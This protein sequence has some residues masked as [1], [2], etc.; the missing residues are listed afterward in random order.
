MTTPAP[1]GIIAAA[2]E[3]PVRLAER[4]MAAGQPV[5]VVALKNTATADFSALPHTYLRVG[6]FKKIL[7]ALKDAGCREVMLAGKFK[8]PNLSE[9]FPDAL[10]SRVAMKIMLAGDDAALKI[11]RDLLAEADLTMVDTTPYLGKTIASPGLIAGAAITDQDMLQVE[12]GC[13]VLKA[14]GE[15]DIGQ[16][17]VIQG[18]RVLAIEAAEGTDEMIY[19]CGDLIDK[20]LGAAVLVKMTKS[21]QD[22]AL[23]PPVIGAETVKACGQVGITI[24][25]IEAGGVIISDHEATL[26]AVKENTASLFGVS[27]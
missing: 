8:R 15:H 3:L 22:K 13:A 10:A 1:M 27:V 7:D 17:V 26:R 6:A 23:D 5:F 11:I 19:R 4:V 25:A 2:G 12:K 9:A 24:I 16:A 18:L 20:D 14:I 21:G